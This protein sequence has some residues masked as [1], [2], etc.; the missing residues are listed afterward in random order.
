MTRS[1]VPHAHALAFVLLLAGVLLPAR[2]SAADWSPFAEESVILLRTA[3]PDGAARETK[4]WIVVLDDHAYVRTNDSR[5][6]AN[7]R[8]G[9]AV[10]IDA[11]SGPLA[12]ATRE[13]EDEA[14]KTRVEAAFKTKYGLLQRIMSVLRTREPTVLELSAAG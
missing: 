1:V 3:D 9:S 13:V 10:A 12:V 4:V 11:G 6:L 14:T 2:T 8:R 5:W 7:I